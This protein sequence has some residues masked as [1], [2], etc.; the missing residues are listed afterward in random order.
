[1]TVKKPRACLE[2]IT[3]SWRNDPNLSATS[4]PATRGY[5]IGLKRDYGRLSHVRFALHKLRSSLLGCMLRTAAG[6]R[7][8]STKS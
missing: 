2:D 8:R 4:D 7:T 1:M 3:V 6:L 5:P